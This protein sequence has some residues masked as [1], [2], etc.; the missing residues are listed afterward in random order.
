[1]LDQRLVRFLLKGLKVSVLQPLLQA[2]NSAILA[3][4]QHEQRADRQPLP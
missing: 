1:M 4:K 2:L 3:Q